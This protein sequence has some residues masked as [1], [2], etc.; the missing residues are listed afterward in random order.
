VSLA[1]RATFLVTVAV[2]VYTGSWS[3]HYHGVMSQMRW[4]ML[5][6]LC[7]FTLGA[8]QRRRGEFSGGGVKLLSWAFA[9]LAILSA[10][11]ST[12][13][14]L[15]T[16][17][18][19][20][21]VALLVLFLYGALWPRLKRARDYH[22]LFNLL[23]ISGAG[24]VGLSWL[25]V[26]LIPGS[27]VRSYTGAWQGVFG[28]PNMLGMM[29]AVVV[30]VLAAKFHETFSARRLRACI[31]WGALA[32][33]SFL[34]VYRSGSRA[35]L[36]GAF[37]GTLAFYGSYYGK[38][39]FFVG[40]L[41]VVLAGP[42]FLVS[43]EVPIFDDVTAMMMRDETSFAELGSGRVQFWQKGWERFRESPLYGHG[44]G[45]AGD[46]YMAPERPFRYHSSFVQIS[47]DLGL[48]G[49][50][51]FCAPM[52]YFALKLLRGKVSSLSS[53]AAR[54]A[55]AGFAAAWVGALFNC[56]FESW[57]YSVGNPM[58]LLAWV[59][60]AAAV[61]GLSEFPNL[62]EAAPARQVRGRVAFLPSERGGRR[63]DTSPAG[64][65]APG[66]GEERG[67]PREGAQDEV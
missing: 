39:I 57:L 13:Y 33:M 24:V 45:S 49:F 63:G 7:A 64:E 37:L 52:I 60:F 38:K 26:L 66:T 21:S 1:F 19:G 17:K 56:L 40:T 50:F 5:A 6:L 62:D 11:Y 9:G 44:F 48:L 35:G 29:L 47:T 54:A 18:R 22:S 41:L 55:L 30:P 15:Y 10:G 12:R 16:L 46:Y 42:Y 8:P 23:A 67:R 27:G 20:V 51:F 59:A 43:E 32:V 53:H 28:N 3:M 36:L 65:G 61:K 2:F 25:A 58:T 34:L 31:L 4:V 14:P